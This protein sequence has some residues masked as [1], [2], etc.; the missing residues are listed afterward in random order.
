MECHFNSR[1]AEGLCRAKPPTVWKQFSFGTRPESTYMRKQ[2]GEPRTPAGSDLNISDLPEFAWQARVK[3]QQYRTCKASR[4]NLVGVHSCELDAVREDW[5]Y[6]GA[7]VDIVDPEKSEANWDC[8]A[9]T[10]SNAGAL[11]LCEMCGKRRDCN[12]PKTTPSPAEVP[13]GNTSSWPSLVEASDTSWAYCE[14]SS[15]GSSW[16]DTGETLFEADGMHSEDGINFLIVESTRVLP[17][18]P[19]W[20]A[21]AAATG[22]AKLDFRQPAMVMPPLWRQQVAPKAAVMQEEDI[23]N[24]DLL[25][26]RRTQ[27]QFRRG[28]TQRRRY[29]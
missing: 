20:A 23:D 27:P 18:G 25:E 11:P 28:G 15:V 6:I 16:V 9:C 8:S 13:D 3:S 5:A 14:V 19:S 10:F 17:D 24:L 26:G 2:A 22:G 1:L 12:V 4:G 21:R 29:R 7:E